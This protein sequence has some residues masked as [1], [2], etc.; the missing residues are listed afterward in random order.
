VLRGGRAKWNAG[1]LKVLNSGDYEF[2][3]VREVVIDGQVYEIWSAASFRLC[4]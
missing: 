4:G 2:D 3:V 1:I